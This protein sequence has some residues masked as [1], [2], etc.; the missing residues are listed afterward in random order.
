MNMF[1]D[2]LQRRRELGALLLHARLAADLTGREAARRALISQS[3]VSKTENGRLIKV[4]DIFRL[5][6]VYDVTPECCH[7]MVA[8]A[9][10]I[11]RDV[12]ERRALPRP[13]REFPR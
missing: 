10:M 11:A 4:V 12:E 5:A 2:E 9:L 7:S 13:L 3:K 1:V 8:L 6:V